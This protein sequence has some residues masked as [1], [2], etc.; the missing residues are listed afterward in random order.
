MKNLILLIACVAFIGL[1]ACGQTNNHVPN[2][3]KTAFSKKFPNVTKMKWTAENGMEWEAEFN[4]EGKEYSANFDVNGMWKETEY[5][6][7][8]SDIPEVVSSTLFKEFEGY[9]ISES[10]ISETANGKVYEFELKKDGKKAEVS[11]DVNGNVIEQ[12]LG[13]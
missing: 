13:K 12:E 2:N 3:V 9:K 7:I 10:V 5:E 1:N 11:I 6:I 8:A 4:M